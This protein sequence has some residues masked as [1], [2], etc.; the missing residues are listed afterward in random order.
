MSELYDELKNRRDAVL[1]ELTASS[2]STPRGAGAKML[3][4]SDESS[5]NNIGTIGGG[6]VEFLCT[7]AAKSL[8]DHKNS[9]IKVYD[10]SQDDVED[11]GMI[12]GGNVEVCFKYFSESDI[13]LVEYVLNLINSSASAWLIT[14]IGE[15]AIDI[16]TYDEV[17]GTKFINGLNDSEVREM[18]N[19]KYSFVYNGEKYFIEPVS[20]KGR[21][22]VFGAGHVS[23]E[24]VPLIE[25]VG[26]KTVVFEQRRELIEGCA[27]SENTCICEG[28]FNNIDKY[29]GLSEYDYA[30]IMT[31]GHRADFEV[32]EQ[33]LRKKLSYVGLIGSRRKI[34]ITRQRLLEAGIDEA[35][36]NKLH[37]PIGLAIKAE[38]PAEIAVS[39]T[40]ELI[41]HRAENR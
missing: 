20:E 19:N 25:H 11:V 3:V 22:V 34:A 14:R 12:C 8:F 23:R 18:L 17:N 31:S 30:V 10:L 35:D 41:L 1:V 24:L 15:S 40:A 32:L 28:E 39:I 7:Q 13:S 6:M 29:I 38:T 5:K 16:G 4:F 2:G 36:I 27:F 26:F 33:I 37:T 9:F 21:V